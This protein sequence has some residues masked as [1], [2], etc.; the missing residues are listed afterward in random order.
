[1]PRMWPITTAPCSFTASS[2]TDRGPSKVVSG[3]DYLSQEDCFSW[4]MDLRGDIAAIGAECEY[5]PNPD[6]S[7]QHGAVYLYRYDGSEWDREAKLGIPNLEGQPSVFRFGESV[8]VGEGFVVV[9][10]EF[11]ANPSNPEADGGSGAAYVFERE[12]E[13]WTLAATL[14]NDDADVQI[15][16]FFGA[17]VSC[18]WQ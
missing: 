2:R 17:S 5:S 3:A 11:A 14:K 16:E 4:A 8:A 7:F 12:G 9:G 15:N 10:T 18:V 6:G 1:M 13:T